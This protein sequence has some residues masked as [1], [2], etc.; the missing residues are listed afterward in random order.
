MGRLSNVHHQRIG[1]YLQDFVVVGCT[2]LFFDP[3]VIF[4]YVTITFLTAILRCLNNGNRRRKFLLY[5][6][7][8]IIKSSICGVIMNFEHNLSKFLKSSSLSEKINE[9]IDNDFVF[10]RKYDVFCNNMYLQ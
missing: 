7:K 8:I 3:F 6:Q 9:S 5:I 10:S 2:R 1:T 4:M